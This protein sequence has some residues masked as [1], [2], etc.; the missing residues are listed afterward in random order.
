MPQGGGCSIICGVDGNRIIRQLTTGMHVFP[1]LIADKVKKY[2]D[3][4][5]QVT[6]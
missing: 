6:G 4:T 1:R 2:V 5:A 3:K